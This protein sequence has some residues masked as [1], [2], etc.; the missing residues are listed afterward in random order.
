MALKL[1]GKALYEV[2][3][4]VNFCHGYLIGMVHVWLKGYSHSAFVTV[5]TRGGSKTTSREWVINY[6]FFGKIS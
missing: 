1:K 2:Y 4:R 6:T 5:I 3:C